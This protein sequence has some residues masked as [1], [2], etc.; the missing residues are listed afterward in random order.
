MFVINLT[1]SFGNYTIDYYY[2]F[3]ES[4]NFL[5]EEE[6]KQLFDIFYM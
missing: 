6:V 5:L 1:D 4:L 3:K 2:F